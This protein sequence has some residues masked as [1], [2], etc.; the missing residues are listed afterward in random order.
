MHNIQQTISMHEQALLKAGELFRISA[1]YIKTTAGSP[2]ELLELLSIDTLRS[3][4]GKVLK[5]RTH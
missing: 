3:I 5:F 2:Y 1:P 4:R